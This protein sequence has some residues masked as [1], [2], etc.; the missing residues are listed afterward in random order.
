MKKLISLLLILTI[1]VG[2]SM[3]QTKEIRTVGTFTKI[4]FRVP[5]KLVLRQGAPQKVELEGD[6]EALAKIE[7]E[8]KGDKLIIGNEERW[9]WSWRDN[10]RIMV[11]ITVKDIT[12]LSVSGSGELITEGKINTDI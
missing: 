3:G 8:L 2:I 7:T 9:N 11:Y 5:G 4:S 10:D 1:G 12:G 6:K